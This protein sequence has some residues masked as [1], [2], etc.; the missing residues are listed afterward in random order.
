MIAVNG[1]K[2]DLSDQENDFV[3]LVYEPRMKL[4]NALKLPRYTFGE[5]DAKKTIT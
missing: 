3:R 4:L 5:P 2:T 1:I